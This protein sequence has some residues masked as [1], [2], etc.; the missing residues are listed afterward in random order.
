[1]VTRCVR[2]DGV[3]RVRVIEEELHA[4]ALAPGDVFVETR[5]SLISPGT[6]L[7]RVTGTKQGASY[8]MRPGYCSAGIVRGAGSGACVRTGDRVLYTGPH[9]SHLLF[10]PARSDGGVIHKLDDATGD[11]E[12]AFLEMCWIAANGILPVDLKFGDTAAVI[13]LGMLGLIAAV[14]LRYLGADVTALEPSPGRRRRAQEMGIPALDPA[15]AKSLCADIVIDASGRSE[16]ILAAAGIALPHGQVVLLG[17]PRTPLEAD[18]TPFFSAV[19]TKML[20]VIGALNRR[21]PYLPQPDSRISMRRT[22]KKLEQLMHDGV[23][24][25]G[26]FITHVIPPQEDVLLAAYEGLSNDPDN[27]LGVVIDWRKS[28]EK[29]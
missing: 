23:L 4:D 26:R 27:Y 29:I 20:H 14:L 12:G 5:V 9:A 13:G 11:T 1:M 22:M 8:P 18:V 16:G 21:Y 6:E 24:D 17:S 7:S 3:R 15:D 28:T 10:D 19:H 25:A 2:V